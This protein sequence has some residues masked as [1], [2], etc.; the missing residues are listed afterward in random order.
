MLRKILIWSSICTFIGRGV[1]FWKGDTP[2]RVLLWDEDLMT[3]ILQKLGV[4]WQ[5]YATNPLTEC[6][7]NNFTN[8]ISILF[9]ATAIS[10]SLF[11]LKKE[12]IFQK[13]VIAVGCIFY[14][15]MV[16]CYTKDNFFHIGQFFEYTMQLGVPLLLLLGNTL[17]PNRYDFLLKISCALVFSCHGLYAIGYYPTPVSFVSMTMNGFAMSELTA[18]QCLYV[19]GIIDI[20]ASVSLFFPKVQRIGL[21]YMIFWGVLTTFARFY[22]NMHEG[23]FFTVVEQYWYQ[24]LYRFVHFLVPVGILYHQRFLQH[25]NSMD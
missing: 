15:L 4:D 6:Y 3:P 16:I 24:V 9:L 7:I 11:F 10:F 19:V 13:I 18:K 12:S 20:I 25:K 5:T 2:F 23:I 17:P 14:F 1:Q 8:T 22:A 21:I